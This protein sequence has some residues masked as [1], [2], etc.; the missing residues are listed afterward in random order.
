MQRELRPELMH[1]PAI[2]LGDLREAFRWIRLANRRLGG[3]AAVMNHL[4]AWSA[5]WPRGRPVTLLDLGTGCADGPLAAVAWARA[6]GHEL[7]VTAVDNHPGA[8]ALA[9]EAAADEPWITVE[10]AD[11]LA[12]RDRFTADQ[13]DY[14]HAGLCLHHFREIGVLTVLAAMDRIARAGVI[15]NDLLRSRAALL[16]VHAATA[17]IPNPARHD[18][19]ASI[20]AAFTRREVV[21]LASR[22]GWSYAAFRASW[23]THRFTMAGEKPRA[24]LV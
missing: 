15:W 10:H 20:R 18:A 24:W 13:F 23:L 14:V 12:L 8:L 1:D 16:A 19:R 21:D 2:A 22:A 7:R 6:A 11:A 17:L 9:R 5:A 3:T 4:R